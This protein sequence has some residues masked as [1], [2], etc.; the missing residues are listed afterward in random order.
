ME[1]GSKPPSCVATLFPFIYTSV[2]QSTAPKCSNIFLPLRFELMV[3]DV[4]YQS[5]L[6]LPTVLPTPDKADSYCKRNEYISLERRRH[7]SCLRVRQNGILP[8][9]V[10]V[11]HS[12]SF[13]LRTWIVGKTLAGFTLS[14]HGDVI[15]P[16]TICHELFA[17]KTN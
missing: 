16:P 14:A 3:K 2:L 10:Q 6:S 8:E 15:L 13:H 12:S 17:R 11:C 1:K 7:I 9:A 5:V 4:L